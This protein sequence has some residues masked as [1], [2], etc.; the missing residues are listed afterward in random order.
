MKQNQEC[1][2]AINIL[3]G[4]AY[5]QLMVWVVSD[6]AW[7]WKVGALPNQEYWSP[8][9]F[10]AAWW[11]R[12][13]KSLWQWYDKFLECASNCHK[14]KIEWIPPLP[15]RY[16]TL[17]HDRGEV[18]N[19]NNWSFQWYITNGQTDLLNSMANSHGPYQA[20]LTDELIKN[21]GE[22]E[23]SKM[24]EKE[25]EFYRTIEQLKEDFIKKHGYSF[26]N[27]IAMVDR[28]KTGRIESR[29]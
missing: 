23:V 6:V 1:I 22:R 29:K 9:G 25:I 4:I 5:S 20:R 26:K 8:W 15:F 3:K 13:W 17:L 16:P 10:W 28:E 7:R 11:E 14:P 2:D 18:P 27:V 21:F 12:G 19:N 24:L